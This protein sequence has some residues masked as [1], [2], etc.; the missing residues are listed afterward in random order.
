MPL[1]EVRI[2]HTNLSPN[3]LHSSDCQE[4]SAKKLVVKLCG[5]PYLFTQMHRVGAGGKLYLP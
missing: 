1:L 4:T 3:Q 5:F 2:P